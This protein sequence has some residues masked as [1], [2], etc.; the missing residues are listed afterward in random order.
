MGIPELYFTRQYLPVHEG[1]SI[2]LILEYSC[3]E[4][5]CQSIQNLELQLHVLLFQLAYFSDIYGSVVLLLDR[6]IENLY[7]G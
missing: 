4:H 6:S 1:A 5:P 3:F 7:V 2:P